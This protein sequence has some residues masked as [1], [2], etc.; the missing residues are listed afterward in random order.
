M[1]WCFDLSFPWENKA[2]KR[3]GA[4]IILDYSYSSKRQRCK[5][6]KV[7]GKTRKKFQKLIIDVWALEWAYVH[8][9]KARFSRDITKGKNGK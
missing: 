9:S 4:K 3:I 7:S 8:C 1:F 2:R 5:R 6:S